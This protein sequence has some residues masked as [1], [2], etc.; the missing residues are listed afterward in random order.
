MNVENATQAT[1]VAYLTFEFSGGNSGMLKVKS[2]QKQLD[3]IAKC[4]FFNVEILMYKM[5]I[6]VLIESS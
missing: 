4:T 1:W 3:R 5:G 6:I 2:M